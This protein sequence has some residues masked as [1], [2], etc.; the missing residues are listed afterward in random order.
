MPAFALGRSAAL[1]MVPLRGGY[2]DDVR[3]ALRA[4]A[5]PSHEDGVEPCHPSCAGGGCGGASRMAIERMESR[6]DAIITPGVERGALYEVVRERRVTRL[7]KEGE[8][9]EEEGEE[10]G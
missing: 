7:E 8:V 2:G 3:H 1:L 5:S 4:M 9:L 6:G 10:E